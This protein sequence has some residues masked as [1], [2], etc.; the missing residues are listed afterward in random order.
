MVN[1][2]NFFSFLLEIFYEIFVKEDKNLNYNDFIQN[3][4]MEMIFVN[5]DQK[6]QNVI[7]SIL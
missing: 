4:T 7:K 6:N 2:D 5:T 1:D 3:E